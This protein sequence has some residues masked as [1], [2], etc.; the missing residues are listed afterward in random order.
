MSIEKLR[1]MWLAATPFPHVVI[2]GLVGAASAASIEAA[3]PTFEELASTTGTVIFNSGKTERN[4][5]QFSLESS[6][7]PA[8]RGFSRM[9]RSEKFVATLRVI[10]G[11][12]GLVADPD[13][14]GGGIHMMTEG[15]RLDVHVDFNRLGALH[16]RLNVLCYFN[17][18][19]EPAWGGGTEIW[20]EE[21][22]EMARAVEPIPDR[23][24][25]FETSARSFHG[26]TPLV[27]PV[28]VARRSFA[29]YYYSPD[30]PPGW[31]G[32]DHSTV[33]RK[34]PGE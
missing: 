10:T 3:F 28:G 22:W 7:P 14:V 31:D 6:F 15:S 29:A 13:L 2:D 19:W 11:I 32:Q 20:R 23:M 5:L 18:G 12:E 21:P 9:L 17:S 1:E 33:F 27:C 16:R 8:L 34:R 25:L 4:K 30:P 26:V 24:L